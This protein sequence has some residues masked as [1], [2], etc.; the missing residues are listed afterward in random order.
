MKSILIIVILLIVSVA[1]CF[2]QEKGLFICDA[3]TFDTSSTTPG[4]VLVEISPTKNQVSFNYG[5]DKAEIF[6]LENQIYRDAAGDVTIKGRATSFNTIALY[7]MQGL[8]IGGVVSRR[9][10][11]PRTGRYKYV[12]TEFTKQTITSK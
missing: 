4:R 8:L 1:G 3:M 7:Y 9:V 11:V 12:Q 10:F 2:A 6:Y 5:T